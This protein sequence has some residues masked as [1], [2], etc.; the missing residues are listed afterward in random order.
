MG[1]SLHVSSRLFLAVLVRS[2]LASANV[3]SEQLGRLWA[4]QRAVACSPETGTEFST[5]S[6]L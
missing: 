5:Q 2:R 4:T 1:L 3:C 6:A